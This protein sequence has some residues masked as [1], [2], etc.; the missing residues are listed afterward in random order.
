MPKI[1]P[2]QNASS[3]TVETKGTAES[4]TGNLPPIRFGT[5]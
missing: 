3:A 1:E 5:F 4:D 2:C